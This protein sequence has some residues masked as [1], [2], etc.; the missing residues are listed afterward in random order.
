MRSYRIFFVADTED[1][2][3]RRNVKPAQFDAEGRKKR[4]EKWLGDK[5]E[6]LEKKTVATTT[7]E[8]E[9]EK[10]DVKMTDA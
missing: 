2:L 5:E 3:V 4:F 10:E 9:G 8:A 6:K 1:E 7:A